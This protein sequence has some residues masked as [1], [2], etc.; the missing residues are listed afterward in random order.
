MSLSESQ[1]RQLAERQAHVAISSVEEYY[2][3]TGMI[4]NIATTQQPRQGDGETLMCEEDEPAASKPEVL[5]T[6]LMQANAVHL[7][8]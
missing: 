2:R 7:N 1:P 4:V 6:R 5:Y 8:Q 3:I